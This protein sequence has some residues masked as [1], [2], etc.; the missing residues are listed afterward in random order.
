MVCHWFILVIKYLILNLLTRKYARFICA[1]CTRR[2]RWS[3]EGLMSTPQQ[4]LWIHLNHLLCM[5]MYKL[6]LP[7][8]SANYYGLPTTVQLRAAHEPMFTGRC[9][10]ANWLQVLYCTWLERYTFGTVQICF[11]RS[12]VILIQYLWRP[13]LSIQYKVD[14]TFWEE[15]QPAAFHYGVWSIC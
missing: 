3:C 12:T 9:L 4:I 8:L 6:S 13:F 10:T 1:I 11:L 2:I 15:T 5:T 7:K 14:L